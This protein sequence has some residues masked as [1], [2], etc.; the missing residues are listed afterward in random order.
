MT[1]FDLP[2]NFHSDPESLLRRTR[3]RLVSPRRS[4]SAVDPVIAS[5]SSPRAMAQKTLHDNSA[6]SASQVPT[7]PEVNT[8]GENFEIK[9]GLI[10]MVQA[11]PF[12]GR[13]L[14][15]LKYPFCYTIRRGFG[16][17]FGMIHVL[18]RHLAPELD[19]FRFCPGFWSMLYFGRKLDIFEDVST[20]PMI[21]Q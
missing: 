3:A 16:K 15:L 6:L 4:L 13:V 21:T 8:G 7:G 18:T 5:S 2:Q 1:G 12:C 14:A 10:M 11:S 20:R 9:T 19:R 17:F